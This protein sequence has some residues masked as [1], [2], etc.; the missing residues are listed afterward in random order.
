MSQSPPDA[1]LA[2]E[3]ARW[4]AERGQPPQSIRALA[5]DLSQRRYFRAAWPDGRH[6]VAAFYPREIGA[7]QARFDAAAELLAAAN[8]RVPAR[9]GI[10]RE[11]GWSL[12]EDLGEATLYECRAAGWPWLLPRLEDAVAT[13]GR[14]ARLD[15]AA[16]VAL[17]SP[18]LDAELLRRELVQTERLFL[19]PAGV[20]DDPG[21]AAPF[22][23]AL[24]E[25][26]EQLGAAPLAPCH[27]DFMARNL[28]PVEGEGV[29]VLDFQDLRLGPAAYDLASLLND[30]LFPPPELETR[31]VAAAG[32]AGPDDEGYLRAVAQRALKAVGTFAAFAARGA[33]RHLP[34]IPPTLRRAARAL[35]RLPETSAAY[36]R[37]APRLASRL[38]AERFC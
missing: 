30:S 38:G 20:L 5:G 24:D 33:N 7:T 1:T 28:V 6:A 12:V 32:I 17:G 8:V 10:D 15:A 29:G 34:L 2:D 26:C 22:A 36:A 27:R 16:V 4:L 13:L 35:E 11:R 9:L 19:A 31:L 3:L 14:I 21:V 18:P 23:A 25:L 37:I